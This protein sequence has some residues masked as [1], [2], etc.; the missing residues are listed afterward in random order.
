MS[1]QL[2]R[3]VENDSPGVIARNLSSVG[4][5]GRFEPRPLDNPGASDPIELL[6][7]EMAQ[8]GAFGNLPGSID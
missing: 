1:V 8:A 6:V 2:M 4:D 5:L 3:D 7:R